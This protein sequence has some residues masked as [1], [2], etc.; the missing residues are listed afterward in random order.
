MPDRVILERLS[1]DWQL[2][3]LP[4]AAQ[5]HGLAVASY[6][7]AATPSA[8]GLVDQAVC[9]LL[10]SFARRGRPLP[11]AAASLAEQLTVQ[12]LGLNC[13]SEDLPEPLAQG[14]GLLQA[15]IDDTRLQW[16]F[17][18]LN[19]GGARGEAPLAITGCSPGASPV[20]A[21]I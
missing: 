6:E 10:R 3:P 1:A 17:T 14:V 18:C 4:P 20:F 21:L 16:I 7:A 5:P 8:A 13:P 19:A 2:P 11:T 12:L 9:E 15:C